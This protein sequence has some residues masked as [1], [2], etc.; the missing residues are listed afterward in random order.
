LIEIVYKVS[1]EKVGAGKV[2]LIRIL[3]AVFV[4]LGDWVPPW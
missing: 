1:F 3:A 2:A 4:F